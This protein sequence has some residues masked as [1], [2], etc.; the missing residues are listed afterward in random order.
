MLLLI[1]AITIF[2]DLEKL[3]LKDCVMNLLI[4]LAT[5]TKSS[6]DQSLLNYIFLIFVGC[7]VLF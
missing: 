4:W 7:K 2:R 5:Y 1:F 3:I 6:S